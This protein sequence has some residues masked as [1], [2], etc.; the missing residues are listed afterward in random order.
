MSSHTVT[1]GGEPVQIAWNQQTARAYNYRASKIGGAPTI[2]DL[3]TP[4]R[5]VAAVT[6]LLWLLLP[7][8][9]AAKYRTPEELYQAI[10]HENDTTTIHAALVAVVAD[11][12]ADDEKKSSS[13]KSPS[14]ESNSD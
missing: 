1:I 6:D 2:R 12:T 9:A 11:M 8:E 10:D 14:P 5:A 7:P 3:S 13:T 4:K